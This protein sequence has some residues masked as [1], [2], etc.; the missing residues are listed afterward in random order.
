MIE[1]IIEFF[2]PGNTPSRDEVQPSGNE[3]DRIIAESPLFFTGLMNGQT[4]G[5]FVTHRNLYPDI[6]SM[7]RGM[8]SFLVREAESFAAAAVSQNS[9]QEP[10]RPI[11]L[12]PLNVTRFLMNNRPIYD[13]DEDIL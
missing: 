1:S 6:T 13:L 5:E 2:F 7:V 3:W 11:K 9:R 12:D 4:M 10:P 8:D